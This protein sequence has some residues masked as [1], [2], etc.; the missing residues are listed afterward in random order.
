M[1]GEAPTT[2][3]AQ[4]YHWFRYGEFQG[5]FKGTPLL[6]RVVLYAHMVLGGPRELLSHLR[7]SLIG[8][9]EKGQEALHKYLD[10][11]H[12]SGY[13][14][15]PFVA[16]DDTP[17]P[18]QEAH[19]LSFDSPLVSAIA[20]PPAYSAHFFRAILDLASQHHCK[21]ILLH[22][23]ESADYG[24]S[25]IPVYAWQKTGASGYPLIGVP[26]NALYPGM[27]KQRFLHYYADQHVNL[28]GSQL[29]TSAITPAVIE[30][31]DESR[32]ESPSSQL[33][34]AQS[35]TRF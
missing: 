20:Q 7:P 10:E 24:E 17:T 15:A 2:P 31:Y 4:A 14:G 25:S 8:N 9:D 33:A 23:P 35:P 6:A 19:L 16:E 34:P 18:A 13:H 12:S 11:L 28:N 30:A 22:I 32:A 1:L 21:L 5:D 26:T 29:F 27:S 3:H